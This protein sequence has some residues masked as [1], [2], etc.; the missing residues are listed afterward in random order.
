MQHTKNVVEVFQVNFV[1]NMQRKGIRPR[2]FLA[3]YRIIVILE[4]LLKGYQ[5]ERE[6]KSKKYL[7]A[8]KAQYS[9]L[10]SKY[11]LLNSF[12]NRNNLR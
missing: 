8:M 10:K 1:V 12:E 6:G 3:G 5:D 11:F 2:N 4:T 9:K 7:P